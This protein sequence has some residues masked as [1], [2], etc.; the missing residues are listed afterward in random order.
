MPSP[1][2][3]DIV[4]ILL[5]VGCPANPRSAAA[6]AAEIRAYGS[7]D[8]AVAALVNDGAG[9]A[10]DDLL[11]LR[12]AL[13]EQADPALLAERLRLEAETLESRAGA[14]WAEAAQF[15]GR[16]AFR[17]LQEEFD[18][19]DQFQARALAAENLAAA[20]ES[21]AMAKRLE[22]AALRSAEGRR[23]ELVDLIHGLAA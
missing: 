22:A 10:L 18:L 9:Q 11:A 23:R 15:H 5:S 6:L 17:R 19:A 1:S 13:A 21:S 20:C 12:C 4:D 2:A 16:A 8:A 14:A 3:D 7:L